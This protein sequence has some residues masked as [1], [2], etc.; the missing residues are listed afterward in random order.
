MAVFLNYIIRPNTLKRLRPI[1]SH[2][3]FTESV[4]HFEDTSSKVIWFDFITIL[5]DLF[6]ILA[7]RIF[8]EDIVDLL[9]DEAS[10]H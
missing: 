10:S 6:L 5:I 2:Q 7:N 4:S 3:P 1:H 9:I 8:A